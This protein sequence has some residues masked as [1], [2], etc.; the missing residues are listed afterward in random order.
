[1]FSKI[2][3]NIL[4]FATFLNFC[5]PGGSFSLGIDSGWKNDPD[6]FEGEKWVPY[7]ELT[8][9]DRMCAKT[10]LNERNNFD[11]DGFLRLLRHGDLPST[12]Y[13]WKPNNAK[14]TINL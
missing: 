2:L 12:R 4:F 14:I 10:A 1:M 7:R 11:N 13:P 5:P 8:Y 9:M 3:R 6:E